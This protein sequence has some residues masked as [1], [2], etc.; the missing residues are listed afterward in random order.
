MKEQDPQAIIPH[1]GDADGELFWHLASYVGGLIIEW[2]RLERAIDLIVFNAFQRR[3]RSGLQARVPGDFTGK[4][5]ILPTILEGRGQTRQGVGWMKNKI[6]RILEIKETRDT[7]VHGY[8]GS[9]ADDPA[10]ISFNRRRFRQARE[11][12]HSLLISESEFRS[13]INDIRILN[14]YLAMYVFAFLSGPLDQG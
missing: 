11:G 4:L 7:L 9:V 8:F 12:W 13:I 2:G 10:T 3:R 14:E 5:E 1:L 6:P